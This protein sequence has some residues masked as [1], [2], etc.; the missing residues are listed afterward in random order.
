MELDPSGDAE[1]ISH[2]EELPQQSQKEEDPLAKHL[3]VA[4]QE[5]F[6]KDSNLVKCIRQTYFRAHWPV[7]NKEVTH[8]LIDVFKELAEMAGLL[9]TEI[10]QVQDQ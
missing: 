4:C 3:R 9:D 7:F 6:C 8:D 5:A 1:P 2:P 10:Y